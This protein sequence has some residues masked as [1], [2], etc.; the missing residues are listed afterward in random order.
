MLIFLGSVLMQTYE[1]IAQAGGGGAAGQETA[2]TLTGFSSTEQIVWVI[3]VVTISMVIV[4]ACVI[5]LE[6]Y[7]AHLEIVAQE[8]FS[9]ATMR[10]CRPRSRI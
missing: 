1:Y 5:L 8:R 2:A 6:A 9:C 7:K 10:S 3:I 4:V